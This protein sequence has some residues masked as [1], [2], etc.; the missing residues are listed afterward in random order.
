[1]FSLKNR[2]VAGN[3][4]NAGGLGRELYQLISVNSAKELSLT[5]V[6]M[7]LFVQITLIEFGVKTKEKSLIIGMTSS[8]VIS[9][10]MFVFGWTHGA[11][12]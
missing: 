9:V 2:M 12:W 6:V 11:R 3:L 8:A 4:L 7:F 1:M 10:A 5:M